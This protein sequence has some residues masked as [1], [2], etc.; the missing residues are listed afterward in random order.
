MTPLSGSRSDSRAGPATFRSRSTRRRNCAPPRERHGAGQ[1]FQDLVGGCVGCRLLLSP[2]T[3][4][5]VLSET[6][7]GRM[8][9]RSEMILATCTSLPM[10]CE[11]SALAASTA[12][13][14]VGT[15]SYSAL[16]AS[17]SRKLCWATASWFCAWDNC[18][19]A[20]PNNN[21]MSPTRPIA[22][23][24]TRRLAAPTARR[25]TMDGGM[26]SRAGKLRGPRIWCRPSCG[27][28]ARPLARWPQWDLHLLRREVVD[29][30]RRESCRPNARPTAD[31]D[32]G[33]PAMANSSADM[34]LPCR[35]TCGS[36]R[37]PGSR[38]TEARIGR[39][40]NVAPGAPDDVRPAR[41]SSFTG[42]VEVDRGADVGHKVG[43][44]RAHR[45]LGRR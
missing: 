5:T 13:Y 23:R 42:R 30:W 18:I 28:E 20:N 29:R 22:A 8:P 16:A 4:E 33:L 2:A 25:R 31:A 10:A 35:V 45:G 6:S 19:R 3:K 14:T 17:A 32:A 36:Q 12:A 40:P 7:S 27:A 1:G 34:D 37:L 26:S 43:Q 41:S 21:S 44:G 15:S 24:R 11:S 38:S 39:R 9:A